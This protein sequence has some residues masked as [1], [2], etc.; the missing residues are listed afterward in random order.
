MA[1]VQVTKES[2]GRGGVDAEEFYK[3][4]DNAD[5]RHTMAH[6]CDPSYAGGRDQEDH[7][8]KASPRQIVHE[9]LS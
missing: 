6:T 9:A 5:C 8:F 7:E 2:T 1:I 4:Q 3:H